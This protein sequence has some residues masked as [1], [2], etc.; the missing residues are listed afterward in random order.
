M[1]GGMLGTA[2][3]REREHSV[4]DDDCEN[5]NTELWH[6]RDDCQSARGPEQQSEEVDHLEEQLLPSGN[7]PHGVEPI[8]PLIGPAKI[9]FI[10]RQP[11]GE[12]VH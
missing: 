6:S 8:R 10:G 7:G 11:V 4:Q 2:L 3:L 12:G 5:C 9:N 1:L